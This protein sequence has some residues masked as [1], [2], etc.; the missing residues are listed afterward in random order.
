MVVAI[1][2][3]FLSAL[4]QPVMGW[5][6]PTRTPSSPPEDQPPEYQTP[7]I[8]T[9]QRSSIVRPAHRECKFDKPYPIDGYGTSCLQPQRMHGLRLPIHWRSSDQRRSD[10]CRV[11]FPI[12]PT[13]LPL[14]ALAQCRRRRRILQ[15]HATYWG[16]ALAEPRGM[17]HLI[18]N[19]TARVDTGRQKSCVLWLADRWSGCVGL[20]I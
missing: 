1:I 17:V 11:A 12:G 9:P 13:L 20:E 10:S 8:S 14:R 7:R 15:S 4:C 2:L 18:N 19:A 6:L 16:E 5:F 3:S